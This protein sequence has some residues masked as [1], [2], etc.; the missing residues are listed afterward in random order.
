MLD[1]FICLTPTER[2]T[3][4]DFLKYKT[5]D[6]CLGFFPAGVTK[7]HKLC[8][9]HTTEIYFSQLWEVQLARWLSGKESA[10]KAG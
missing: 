9:L 4:S 2:I 3:Y 8:G 10:C 1:S 7:Y 5:V 6:T